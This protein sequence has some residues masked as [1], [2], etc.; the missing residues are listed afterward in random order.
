MA[1]N[2]SDAFGALLVLRGATW[3]DLRDFA[4][5]ALKR[6]GQ[7]ALELDLAAL[8]LANLDRLLHSQG[9]ARGDQEKRGEAKKPHLPK[10]KC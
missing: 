5:V 10:P 8:D 1:P 6:D 9:G 7:V 3:Y 4:A 2:S